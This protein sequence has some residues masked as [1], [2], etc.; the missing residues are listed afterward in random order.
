MNPNTP[1]SPFAP[2]SQADAMGL[3]SRRAAIQRVA[4]LVGATLTPTFLESIAQAQAVGA[5]AAKPVHLSGVQF[6]VVDAISERIL[7]RTDTPGA[8]DVGVPT[9]IDL[10]FGAYLTATDKATWVEGL[11]DV[12]ARSR[13]AQ[14]KAFA[15]LNETQQDAILKS[16]ANESQRKEK[17]F[18]HQIRDL[19]LV[20]YF[21]SEPVGRNVTQFDPIPGRYDACLPLSEVGNRSW[22]R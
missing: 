20:G 3:L 13:R 21:T 12:D 11:A 10:M 7:P 17:T 8:R 5:M 15:Q 4:L 18:F 16:V 22:T 9:F 19:T 14:G 2:E 1:H 6:A